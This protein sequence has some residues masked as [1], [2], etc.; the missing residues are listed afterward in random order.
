MGECWR[1][2]WKIHAHI[3][4]PSYSWVKGTRLE[5]SIVVL[6]TLFLVMSS[7][8]RTHKVLSRAEC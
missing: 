7:L 4:N 3:W 2:I 8:I 5:I 1:E 6:L